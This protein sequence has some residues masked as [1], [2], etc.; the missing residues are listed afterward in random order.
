MTDTQPKEVMGALVDQDQPGPRD[1]SA[2]SKEKKREAD[3]GPWI[4]NMKNWIRE[5]VA[6]AR[7]ADEDGDALRGHSTPIAATFRGASP[8][9]AAASE[10][11][12]AR[13][14]SFTFGQPA[15]SASVQN[16]IRPI[17]D[18]D[19]GL[20][21]RMNSTD[22]RERTSTKPPPLRLV[23]SHAREPS[24]ISLPSAISSTS[25]HSR[26]P[27]VVVMTPYQPAAAPTA[28]SGHSRGSSLTTQ[29]L[30]G[31]LSSKKSLPDLRKSHA[32][33]MQ[34]RRESGTSPAV[35]V[36]NNSARTPQS[37]ISVPSISPW[38]LPQRSPVSAKSFISSGRHRLPR[39]GSADMLSRMRPGGGG[40][41]PVTEHRNSQETP[42]VDDSRNSYFRR[43]STLPVSTISKTIPET[44]LKFVDG[45]RG[46]LFALSQLHSALKQYLLFAAD[47]RVAGM[48]SRVLDPAGKY[49]TALINALDRFDS[50][51]RRSLPPPA[52]VKGVV[53]ATKDSIA[54]FA[55]VVA[56]LRLQIPALRTADTRYTRTLLLMVYG[57][58][59]EISYSWS[60][61][62]PLLR[63]MR[64]EGRARSTGKHRA[65]ALGSF[66][67]RTPI[68]PIP[69]RGESHSPP[70][71][72]RTDRTERP[73]AQA[74][75]LKT[76]VSTSDLALTVS[77]GA[78]R[79]GSGSRRQGGSFSVQD[80]E[81]GMLMSRSAPGNARSPSKASGH[82]PTDSVQST[83]SSL[84]STAVTDS[85]HALEED[86]DDIYNLPPNPPFAYR[87]NRSNGSSVNLPQTPPDTHSALQPIAMV[88]VSS[89]NSTRGHKTTSS[90]GSSHLHL[91]NGYAKSRNAS[92][93]IP[94][95]A[96]RYDIDDDLL[97]V[98]EAA[99]EVAFTTWLR[100]AEDIGGLPSSRHGRSDSSSSEMTSA[101]PAGISPRDHNTMLELLSTSET[102]TTSLR[103]SLMGIRAD[104]HSEPSIHAR[105]MLHG[106]S[107]AF[108]KTVVKVTEL[109]MRLSAQHTFSTAV[110]QCCAKLVQFTREFAILFQVSHTRP[111]TA[112]STHVSSAHSKSHAHANSSG[113]PYMDRRTNGDSSRSSSPVSATTLTGARRRFA[114]SS[115]NLTQPHSADGSQGSSATFGTPRSA[116]LR[117]LRLPSRQAA[118]GR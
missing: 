116:G 75:P 54:A 18:A 89:G 114:A 35:P 62:A 102:V 5:R 70:S 113:H 49:T 94:G 69:E 108:V 103:E 23:T 20:H 50:M 29:R 58:M 77:P 98:I 33:I 14:Q 17:R 80:V 25:T 95:S 41:S 87:A 115:D 12:P 79:A 66:S 31:P 111:G 104:P 19:D 27:S 45:I 36:R 109:V 68:S 107:E 84:V 2:R 96:G 40:L 64:G 13:M 21:G 97:D 91:A 10:S 4:A 110:R 72:S 24:Q 11:E 22:S 82:Q 67:D 93:D 53:D 46:I 74:S 117:G 85:D 34:D 57:S 52:A 28:G 71:V 61:M 73:L 56:M 105:S 38:S 26:Q 7:A 55:K 30:S 76:S 42:P 83:L 118:L 88:P 39:V 32:Q 3:L 112:A 51:S 81:R 47:D 48:F 92:V 16:T 9:L 8:P 15:P 101:R 100:L 63:G 99:T 60:T 43:L 86:D 106:Q 78:D 90:A 59:S 65:L 1:A 37:A 44:L 6:E